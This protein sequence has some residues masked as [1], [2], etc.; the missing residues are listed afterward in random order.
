MDGKT[1]FSRTTKGENEV[2]GKTTL[3]AGDIKRALVM[4]DGIATFAEISKRAVP[5][6]RDSLEQMFKELMQGGYIRENIKVGDI[7]ALVT[8]T[9]MVVPPKMAKPDE[10]LV[11]DESGNDLDFAS[12]FR[13][14]PRELPTAEPPEIKEDNAKSHVRAIATVKAKQ[15]AE[16][17][18]RAATGAKVKQE[19]AAQVSVEAESRAAIEIQAR[20]LEAARE[21][22][23]MEARARTEAERKAG[24]EAEARARAEAEEKVRREAEI[25]ARIEVEKKKRQ[26]EQAKAR[27]EA[28]K[29]AKREAEARARAEAEEPE[30]GGSLSSRAITA[31]V[32]FFDVVGYTKQP[33]NKQIEIKKQFNTL[34]SGCMKALGGGEHI[35][36]DTGD[37]AAIGFMQHPEGALKVAMQFRKTVTANQ[38]NDYPDMEVRIGIHLG[39]IN[40]AQD[41]NGRS[42]MVG[43]GINDAQRVM[44]FA[45]ADQVYIS[46]SYYDFVSRLS[47]EYASLFHYQGA[48]A[49]KHGRVHPVYRLVDIEMPSE[50]TESFQASSVMAEAGLQPFS[51][52]IPDAGSSPTFAEAQA[53]VD[54]NK[55]PGAKTAE[56]NKERSGALDD[57]HGAETTQSKE[58]T[59]AEETSL[60]EDKKK[61][62]ENVQEKIWAE[63]ERRA[64]EA[65]RA[66]ALRVDYQPPPA[67]Q[68]AVRKGTPVARVKR[69]P[70]PWFK[71]G[72]GTLVVI[73]ALLFVAPLVIPT[74]EYVPAIEKLLSVKLRQPVYIGRLEGRLLPTPRL[75]LIDIS[76]GDA[77]QIKARLVRANFVPLTLLSQFKL[78]DNIELEGAQVS[79]AA[80]QPVSAW[81]RQLA[82]D[83]EYPIARIVLRE[84]KLE[85]DGLELSDIG[86]ELSFDQTGKFSLAKLYAEGNKYALELKA[87]SANKS[88]AS[89]LVRGSALPLLPNWVFDDLTAEGEL[90]GNEL[91]ISELDGH[92]M[93]GLL[94]GN[95]RID[96]RSGWRVQGSL[97]AK[98]VTTQNI[99]RVMSGDMDGTAHFQMHA[100]NLTKLAD[101]ATLEGSFVIKKGLINGIGVVETARLRSTEN[102]PGGRTHFDELSGEV[103]YVKDTYAF[104]QLKMNAGVLTAKGRLDYAGEQVDGSISAELALREGM[105]PIPLILGGTKENLTLRAVR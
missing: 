20:A 89:I 50:E 37:G 73:L 28:E 41:M 32:L 43:D 55:Q 38:H 29:R 59:E 24:R 98:A 26:E 48:L 68:S 42:N 49:D 101:T 21:K 57:K 83:T 104:R 9:R 85:A 105:G 17:R 65:A 25:K 22:R 6:L 23:E 30:V 51:F 71:V 102:M 19:T 5:S 86:G 56:Q 36:L 13:A 79:G 33:V 34:V 82:A 80:L 61:E 70:L 81:L 11:D 66:S 58:A 95:A 87:V 63:A 10:N 94:H 52:S 3:L 103:S 16:A 12:E 40:V 77:K 35:I 39:P 15:A 64:K 45:G 18:A 54:G 92:I 14:P 1:I 27:A 8:P 91:L 88:H 67:S 100:E 97:E 60:S 76:I 62:L 31:T 99:L 2:R 75:D 53:T 47:G 4:V 78:I 69:K 7:P 74:R 84:G 72:V 46:R 90:T 96:W 44:S 93:G